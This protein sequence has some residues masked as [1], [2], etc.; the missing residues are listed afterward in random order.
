MRTWFV[1]LLTCSFTQCFSQIELGI[2]PGL[3]F[4]NLGGS[5]LR[6]SK[7]AANFHMGVMGDCRIS[8]SRVHLQAQVLYSPLGYRNTD[9]QATD[10]YGNDLGSIRSHRISYIQ[11]PVYFLYSFQSKAALIKAGLGPWLAFQTGDRMKTEGG[12]T[13][14]NGTALP[15]FAESINKVLSGIGFQASAQWTTLVVSI[16]LQQ[17][18]NGVYRNNSGSTGPEWTLNNYGLSVGYIFHF[19]K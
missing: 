18:F 7:V 12:E 4:S 5:D 15:T 14:G 9:I 10:N 8:K 11:T 16:Y 13:F 2:L 3:H 6:E 1:L 19:G 17:S